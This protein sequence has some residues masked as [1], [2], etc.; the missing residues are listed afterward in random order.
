MRI[1]NQQKSTLF[2]CETCLDEL[3]PGEG[4]WVE[5]PLEKCSICGDVDLQ[6]QEELYQWHYEND[7]M[8]L[9]HEEGI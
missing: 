5:S 6:T 3:G 4:K 9:Q 7:M 8:R 1:Y 2:M